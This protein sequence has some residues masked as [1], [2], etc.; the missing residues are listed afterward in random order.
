MRALRVYT[1][2][3]E[4]DPDRLTGVES[5][6]ALIGEMKRRWG[7]TVAEVIAYGEQAEAEAN[8]LE[9]VTADIDSIAAEAQQLAESVTDAAAELSRQRKR[10][11]EEL[12]T[13]VTRE[14]ESLRLPNARIEFEFGQIPISETARSLYV[15]GHEVG[16]D[17]TGI[18]R[19]RNP[20][21]E[22]LGPA[23]IHPLARDGRLPV[24]DH[25]TV[26][27]HR[28]G[29]PAGGQTAPGDHLLKAFSPRWSGVHRS[30][31]AGGPAPPPTRAR[32][33]GR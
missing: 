14:C 7:D 20:V 12:V 10:A 28:I 11:A 19:E 13:A 4:L 25:P 2:E 30:G 16:F 8:R 17:Q 24:H 18:D 27:D 15:D 6:L 23:R 29:H 33:C 1:D 5:R 9:Q 22:D 31:S 3:L 26:Q 21:H 32:A